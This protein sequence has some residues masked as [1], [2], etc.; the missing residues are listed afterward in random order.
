MPY[1]PSSAHCSLPLAIPS[2]PL[3]PN[4]KPSP[5]IGQPPDEL[6][7]LSLASW[8]PSLPPERTLVVKAQ[9]LSLAPAAPA[10]SHL[11]PPP[12]L[13]KPFPSL[14]GSRGKNTR[15]L[16]HPLGPWGHKV[17]LELSGSPL[18]ALGCISCMVALPHA[19]RK[20]EAQKHQPQEDDNGDRDGDELRIQPLSTGWAGKGAFPA[21]GRAGPG[22]MCPEQ[23]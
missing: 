22:Q 8:A 14:A 1:P 16:D 9:S 11:Q 13:L 23:R 15:P 2:H 4:L 10:G 5:R 19:R 18:A 3:T 12:P 7:L 17:L 6:P 20:G 21:A